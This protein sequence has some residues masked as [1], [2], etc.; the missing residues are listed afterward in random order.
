MTHSCVTYI[1]V[2]A[3]THV[4]VLMRSVSLRDMTHT[5]VYDT[6]VTRLTQVQI[7]ISIEEKVTCLSV[8]YVNMSVRD[9][10]MFVGHFY[11]FLCIYSGACEGTYICAGIRAMW[12]YA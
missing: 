9:I 1:R 2:M 12:V 7:D 10:V 8:T 3:H 11:G 5:G 6:C 4:L